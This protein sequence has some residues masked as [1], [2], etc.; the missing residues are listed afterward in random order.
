M[1]VE[2]TDNKKLFT[3]I[4]KIQKKKTVKKKFKKMLIQNTTDQNISQ[5]NDKFDKF[6]LTKRQ[7]SGIA[8]SPMSGDSQLD[9]E[10]MD[11]KVG[12]L[13]ISENSNNSLQLVDLRQ[14]SQSNSD[15]S[16]S[17]HENDA[18]DQMLT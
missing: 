8:G 18:A 12:D 5:L 13:T 16:D 11:A 14:N 10:E 2:L 4:S 9:L 3:S 15:S 17:G 1:G 7:D 6:S